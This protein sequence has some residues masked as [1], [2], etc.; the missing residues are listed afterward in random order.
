M[1][2]MQLYSK[3]LKES[4]ALCRIVNVVQLVCTRG[5]TLVLVWS[6][7]CMVFIKKC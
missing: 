7:W 2:P 6:V 1:L 3:L 4:N 5:Y